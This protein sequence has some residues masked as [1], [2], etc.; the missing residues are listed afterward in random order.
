LYKA[1]LRAELTRRCDV[2]WTEVDE[3]GI[4]EIVGVPQE[5]AD[6]WSARRNDL[7]RV[8]NELIADGEA[9]MGRTMTSGERTEIY[10]T[11][12][13]RV[14]ILATTASAKVEE[15]GCAALLL[16]PMVISTLPST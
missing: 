7:K 5:L 12:F 14:M 13:A 6:A 16:K 2:A 1:A 8:A 3:N 10:S 11:D 9:D 4:A 15:N